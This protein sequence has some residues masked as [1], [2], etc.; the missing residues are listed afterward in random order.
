ML[1]GIFNALLALDIKPGTVESGTV[2]TLFPDVK[3][4]ANV[5]HHLF[6]ETVMEQ[7]SRLGTTDAR[8]MDGHVYISNAHLEYRLIKRA[9]EEEN[10]SHF[11]VSF[12]EDSVSTDPISEDDV[13]DLAYQ[14]LGSSP[15][16]PQMV[17]HLGF[18]RRRR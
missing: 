11:A 7:F 6:N 3:W 10:F 9:A 14:V 12:K 8:R 15:P 17:R 5:G 18:R 2:Y 16:H 4:R 13:H 1:H